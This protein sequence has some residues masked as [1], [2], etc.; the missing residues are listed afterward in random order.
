MEPLC[1]GAFEHFVGRLQGRIGQGRRTGS[2]GVQAIAEAVVDGPRLVCAR[3]YTWA[4]CRVPW[5]AWRG[6][7][8]R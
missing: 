6:C 3:G 1:D 4:E 5:S 7:S 8:R 2:T